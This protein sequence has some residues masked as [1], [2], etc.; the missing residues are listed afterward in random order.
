MTVGSVVVVGGTCGGVSIIMFI[1]DTCGTGVSCSSEWCGEE[2]YDMGGRDIVD[3]E[4]EEDV[5]E[6]L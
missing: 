6:E 3:G 2:E 4:E 1:I 5:D